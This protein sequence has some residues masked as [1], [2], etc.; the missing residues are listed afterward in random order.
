MTI[1]DVRHQTANNS[2]QLQPDKI[3]VIVTGQ[4]TS[5]G[6]ITDVIQINHEDNQCL[7]T[8]PLCIP[9]L[10]QLVLRQILWGEI[11]FYV[12]V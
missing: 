8:C 10:W 6:C 12:Q 2:L 4:V 11:R 3:E 5:F 9:T 1:C 7:V